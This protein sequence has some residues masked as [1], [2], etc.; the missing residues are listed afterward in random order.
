MRATARR[1]S[2][3]SGSPRVALVQKGLLLL[4]VLRL[5]SAETAKPESPSE[6]AGSTGFGAI[7]TPSSDARLRKSS[8]LPVTTPL[9]SIVPSWLNRR[10]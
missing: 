2:R 6:S 8:S 3:N 7:S 9:A 1:I 5:T 10:S 4:S